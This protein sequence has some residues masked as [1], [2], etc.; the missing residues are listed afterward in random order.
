MRASACVCALA[1][2]GA[3]RCAVGLS[4]N[5]GRSTLAFCLCAAALVVARILRRRELVRWCSLRQLRQACSLKCLFVCLF[6]CLFGF[7]RAQPR[8]ADRTLSFSLRSACAACAQR[9][10]LTKRHK[11]KRRPTLAATAGAW[12]RTR[13]PDNESTRK[14]RKHT[15]L[16]ECHRTPRVCRARHTSSHTR[17]GAGSRH[18]VYRRTN[19]K[20]TLQRAR[21]RPPQHAIG[22]MDG[23]T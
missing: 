5:A 23:N 10:A 22:T 7:W 3:C 6:V 1:L 18:G 4:H 14:A 21:V 16:Q 12:V 13:P 11:H 9:H 19:R 20:R 2:V 17:R 15:A 8:T